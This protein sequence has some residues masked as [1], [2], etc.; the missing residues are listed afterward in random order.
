MAKSKIQ[1]FLLGANLFLNLFDK[2]ILQ[3]YHREAVGLAVNLVL[4]SG[5]RLRKRHQLLID[6]SRDL[7]YFDNVELVYPP[8]P[9]QVCSIFNMFTEN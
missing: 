3:P 9:F 4:S 8:D 1:I 6:L 2:C 5:T 7:K